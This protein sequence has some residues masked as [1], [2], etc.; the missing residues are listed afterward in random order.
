MQKSFLTYLN[1]I[2]VSGVMIK[3]IKNIYE[4]VKNFFNIEID[5]LFV[6]N[7]INNNNDKEF[8]S[9]WFF[10]S[11]ATIECKDFANKDDFDLTKMEN[12]FYIHITKTDYNFANTPNNNSRITINAQIGDVLSVN[13]MATGNNCK[14]AMNIAQKYLTP[15]L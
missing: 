12:L 10:T 15:T 4:E 7:I 9:L 2:Q 8:V 1:D 3:R 5:D 6:S 11:K 14:Y 13:L